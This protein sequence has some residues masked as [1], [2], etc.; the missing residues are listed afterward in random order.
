MDNCV[1]LSSVSYRIFRTFYMPSNLHML[2]SANTLANNSVTQFEWLYYIKTTLQNTNLELVM[3][4]E[5][6]TQ[7]NVVA[8]GKTYSVDGIS[9]EPTQGP[10]GG[11]NCIQFTNFLDVIFMN[12]LIKRQGDLAP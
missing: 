6:L 2:D 9:L 12:T 4:Q 11:M 3:Q 7:V 1:T 5:K 8:G 10:N